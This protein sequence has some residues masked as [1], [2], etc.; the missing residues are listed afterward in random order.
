MRRVLL[1][2][3]VVSLSTPAA[4]HAHRV[5]LA[6]PA[7]FDVAVAQV[8]YAVAH[9][10]R[11]AL[12]VALAGPTGLDYV[13]V[14]LPRRQPKHAVVALVAVVNRRPRGSQAPDLARV[15][16]RTRPSRAMGAPT[17]TEAT[18]VL[19][20]PPAGASPACALGSLVVSDLRFALRA[21]L[22]PPGF[23]ARSTIVQALNAACGR[24]VA[25]S[26]LQAV[27]PPAT[28][29][30][31]PVPPNPCPPCPPRERSVPQVVCP[32]LTTP[33][34]CPQSAA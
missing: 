3:L 12:R 7:Q 25:A 16:L 29:P 13:V 31:E 27:A 17:V 34:P 18:N 14:A 11:P 5:R 19:A 22:P 9:G 20:R 23:G 26:F 6:A 15:L 28:V 32:L 8:R 21:G 33:P 30:P 24:A 4:A 2:A 10:P 1:A